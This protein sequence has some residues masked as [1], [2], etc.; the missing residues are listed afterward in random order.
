MK[1]MKFLL[2]AIVAVGMYKT[3]DAQTYNIPSASATGS[4]YLG[5]VT[6]DL[7][8]KSTAGSLF[9]N[10][11]GNTTTAPNLG[12]N[13]DGNIGVGLL[14]SLN[15]GSGNYRYQPSLTVKGTDANNPWPAW[16]PRVTFRIVTGTDELNLGNYINR[17]FIQANNP[18]TALDLF[19]SEVTIANGPTGSGRLKVG[20]YG[21][22]I[23][24]GYS[25]V[26]ILKGKLVVGNV[27]GGSPSTPVGYS[28]YVAQGILTEKVKVAVASSGNWAD[29]VFDKNY[30]LLSLGE[31]ES[32][33][34]KNKHLPGVPSAEE[35]VKEGIDMATMDAKLL[36]KIEELTLY[37]I[38][39]KKENE[40][41]KKEIENL[42]SNSK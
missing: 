39:L 17:S 11:N 15:P 34:Q 3:A 6:G 35:V 29:Y 9:L 19:A 22:I 10:T 24:S 1:K 27:N 26:S 30:K 5:T 36:E 21:D 31:V 18:T 20:I 23:N 16:S 33:I 25:A 12:V 14:P 37:M 32:Y 8:L 2:T 41:M 7:N 38:E 42:K 28:L 4:T 40:V 13:T